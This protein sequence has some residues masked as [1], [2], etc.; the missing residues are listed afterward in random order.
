[1]LKKWRKNENNNNNNEEKYR[2]LRFF[3]SLE[4]ISVGILDD[5]FVG[6][7]KEVTRSIQKFL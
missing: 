7:Q 1:M 2:V 6:E 5:P 3:K 4:T